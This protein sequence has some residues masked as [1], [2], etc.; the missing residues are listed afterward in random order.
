MHRKSVFKPETKI[1]QSAYSNDNMFIS[2]INNDE[3]L[4][5]D[6]ELFLSLTD[7]ENSFFIDDYDLNILFTSPS[8]IQLL[9]DQF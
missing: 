1:D 5:Q 2:L 3:E 4:K 8:K 9:D 6:Y 7:N